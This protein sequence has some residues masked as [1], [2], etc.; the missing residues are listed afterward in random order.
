MLRLPGKRKKKYRFADD[1]I[2]KDTMISFIFTGLAL[3]IILGV[4]IASAATGGKLSDK[5]GVLL[6]MAGVMSLTGLIFGGLSF[7]VVEGDNNAKRLSVLL[8]LVAIAL[9][10]VLFF[11]K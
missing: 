5:I 1:L 8:S 11:M 6:L 10:V 3:L 9:L 7:K 4:V 2:A